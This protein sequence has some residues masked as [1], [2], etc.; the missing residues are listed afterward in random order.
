MASCNEGYDTGKNTLFLIKSVECEGFQDGVT[1]DASNPTTI[2]PLG[3]VN[4]DDNY[5]LETDAGQTTGGADY[6]KTQAVCGAFAFIAGKSAVSFQLDQEKMDVTD[7][8]SS[9][10]P[11]QFFK[12][13]DTLTGTLE[14][15]K[16]L[17]ES[18]WMGAVMGGWD[19]V[20]RLYYQFPT[21]RKYEIWCLVGPNVLS[22]AATSARTLVKLIG[23]SFDSASNPFENP[24]KHSVPFSFS[25]L[26]IYPNWTAPTDDDLGYDAEAGLSTPAGTNGQNGQSCLG[27]AITGG[28]GAGGLDATTSVAFTADVA[29]GEGGEQHTRLL[30]KMH[31]E[32]A[33]GP[34]DTDLLVEISGYEANT[35]A[36]VEEQWTYASI[37]AEIGGASG[38]IVVLTNNY[39]AGEVDVQ[40]TVG[41][42]A[43]VSAV[44]DSY[45]LVYDVDFKPQTAYPIIEV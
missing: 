28:A 27:G 25:K 45:A 9:V 7:L 4:Y 8:N 3:T 1:Y 24:I 6:L 42:T 2:P 18:V 41:A 23:V 15:S 33:A 30:M 19:S 32:M 40:L 14:L 5:T 44:A 20:T 31:F 39:F 12:G 26:E 11:R 43:K 29:D 34:L 35:G 16:R 36:W 10:I 37:V 17:G 13:T 38:N 21:F 22:V